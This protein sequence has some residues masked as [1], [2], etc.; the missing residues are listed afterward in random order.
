LTQD[1]FE[2]RYPNI[3]RFVFEQGWIE[4]GSDDYSPSFVRAL[5]PGGM[6]WEGEPFYDSLDD[7]FA[8]LERGL[9]QWVSENLGDS[10]E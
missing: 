10:D 7:A 8:D 4:L 2:R 9:A 6:V 3:T 1:D 5:D